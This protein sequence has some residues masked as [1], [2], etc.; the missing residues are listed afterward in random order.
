MQPLPLL[1]ELDKIDRY[2][3]DMVNFFFKQSKLQLGQAS[4]RRPCSIDLAVEI[5]AI[6]IT[7]KIA[8][9]GNECLKLFM[10]RVDLFHF[11]TKNSNA[12]M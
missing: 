4:T 5:I 8:K 10:R 1:R 12:S 6:Q 7:F 9:E 2:S 3:Q 11:N